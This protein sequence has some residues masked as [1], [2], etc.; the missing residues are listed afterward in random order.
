[1]DAVYNKVLKDNAAGLRAIGI[2]PIPYNTFYH[3]IDAFQNS[4]EYRDEDKSRNNRREIEEEFL[5]PSSDELS[6]YDETRIGEYLDTGWN[7]FSVSYITVK[8]KKYILAEQ[9]NGNVP[10]S[11]PS[12][13]D[14]IQVR[15]D[16]QRHRLKK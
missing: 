8:G 4:Q 5:A 1:M 14:G 9:I 3:Y 10:N 2:D 11:G 12:I 16:F 7:L 6:R 13:S 15:E